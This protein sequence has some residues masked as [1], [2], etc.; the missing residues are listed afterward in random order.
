[1]S[2]SFAGLLRESDGLPQV[3]CPAVCPAQGWS[4]SCQLPSPPTLYRCQKIKVYLGYP[5]VSL[6][7][8]LNQNVPDMD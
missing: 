8:Q 1:M 7:P 2:P 4:Q 5:F 3:K 6:F